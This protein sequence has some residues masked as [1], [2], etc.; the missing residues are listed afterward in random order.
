[1]KELSIGTFTKRRPH[2]IE[3][4]VRQ[5]YS[6]SGLFLHFT[7]HSF[8]LLNSIRCPISTTEPTKLAASS[9]RRV[10]KGSDPGKWR[11]V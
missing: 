9:L 10:G 4:H 5:Q 1:M 7:G 11:Q 3:N 2:I 8:S 6:H